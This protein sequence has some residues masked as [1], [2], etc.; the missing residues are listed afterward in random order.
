MHPDS[1]ELSTP[2]IGF[3]SKKLKTKAIPSQ[4]KIK[5]NSI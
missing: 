4:T 5:I 1:K 2:Y 3:T